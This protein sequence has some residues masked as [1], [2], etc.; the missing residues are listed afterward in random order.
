MD[1]F[2]FIG[3]ADIFFASELRIFFF[4][5]ELGRFFFLTLASWIWEEE[6]L[7]TVQAEFYAGRFTAWMTKRLLADEI[8]ERENFWDNEEEDFQEH[9]KIW[10][11]RKSQGLW[12]ADNM[13]KQ[14]R[15]CNFFF[16]GLKFSENFCV[17]NFHDF[18]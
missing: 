15:E 2:F 17:I 8:F 1:I 6:T 16:P 13:R 5:S 18:F 11:Q 9:V 12:D 10:S 4:A 7:S 3:V 14:A